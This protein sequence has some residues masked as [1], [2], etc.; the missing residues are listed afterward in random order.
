MSQFARSQ[1]LIAA[2]ISAATLI[3]P[4]IAAE[5]TQVPNFSPDRRTGWVAGVPD[6]ENPVGQDFLQ[7]PS[8]PGPVTFDKGH[9][10]RDTAAARRAGAQA[11]LR[12]ADLSNPILQPW[13]RE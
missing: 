12:V 3:S 7:P 8:G 10:Y 13:V 9:P 4:A 5:T 1:N 11:I 6:G 2:F